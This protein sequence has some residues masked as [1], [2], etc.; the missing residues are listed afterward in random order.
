MAKQR[1][2]AQTLGAEDLPFRDRV[3][4]WA[5]ELAGHQAG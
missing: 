4:G 5:R 3:E 1:A 2:I